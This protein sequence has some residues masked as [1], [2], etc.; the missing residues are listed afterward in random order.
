MN[1][2]VGIIVNIENN[3]IKNSGCKIYLILKYQ[4]TFNSHIGEICKKLV[5]K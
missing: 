3:P 4:L 1:K 2:I 5:R